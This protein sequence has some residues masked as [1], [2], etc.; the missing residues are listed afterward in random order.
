MICRMLKIE[1]SRK[2][3]NHIN[4]DSDNIKEINP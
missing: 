3:S 1:K 4:P 2:S